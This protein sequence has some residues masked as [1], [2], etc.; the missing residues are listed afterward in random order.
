MTKLWSALWRRGAKRTRALR[1]PLRLESLEERNLLSGLVVA[2]TPQ[3]AGRLNATAAIAANDIWAVGSDQQVGNPTLAEHFNG[4]TWSVV[5]TPSG[6][7]GT[8]NGVSGVASNDVWAVGTMT[9]PDNPDF[10]EQFIEH[11]NGKSWSVVASPTVEGDGLN[12]VVAI[13]AN[14]VWAVGHGAPEGGNALVEHWDG[15]SWSVVSSPVF[16]NI[17]GLLSVSADS[18]ND[19]WAVGH[20]A[21]LRFDGTTWSPAPRG[22]GGN[23]VGVPTKDNAVVALSPTDVWVVGQR[24]ATGTHLIRFTTAIEQWNGTSW[25]GVASPAT[26]LNTSLNGIA[27]I[28]A[29]DILAVGDGI[30]STGASTTLVEQWN[31]TSW[32]ILSSPNPG[33]FANGLSAVT[34]LSDG[35]VAAVGFQESETNGF[36]SLILQNSSGAGQSASPMVQSASSVSPLATVPS[37]H[38]VPSPAINGSSLSA[39]AALADND[40][41]AVGNIVEHWNGTSWSVVPT[42]A[43]K[44]G[45]FASVAGAASNDVWAVGNQSTGNGTLIEHWNGTSWSVISG[46]NVPNGSFLLGVTAV[47]SNDVWAVGNQPSSAIL[48]PFIEHWNG[49]SWSVV[50]SPQIAGEVILKGVS[51]DSANDVWAVGSAKGAGLVEHWNG[52]TWSVVPSPVVRSNPNNVGGGS[53]NAVTALSPTN[54]WAVGSVPGPPPTDIGPAIEHW[55][56]TSWEFVAPASHA[57]LGESIAAVSANNIWAIIG[58]GAEQWNGT[59]WSSIAN[60]S[61]V[62]ALKGVTALSDGTVVAVGVGTNNSAVIVSNDLSSGPASTNA[63]ALALSGSPVQAAG[64]TSAAPATSMAAPLDASRMDQFFAMIAKADQP[65]WIVG[66]S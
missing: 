19:I 40:I 5:P 65:W 29:N 61:G 47:A 49:T 32:S 38:V 18:A 55:N 28:S 24:Q 20:G 11:W 58:F 4:K 59:S 48:D 10:G 12:S 9:G 56:G 45:N 44:S 53:L 63:P 23:P 35:T 50:P 39:T 30:S 52:Q 15:T 17:G 13:S 8:F 43:V 16:A 22:V 14:N 33:D 57:G 36:S 3:I 62:Y 60:P 41:W 21:I 31:G 2:P 51:A 1:T 7:E 37:L 42:P 46:A 34:A 54:V 27:A 25:N 6:I 66:R 64:T 26:G